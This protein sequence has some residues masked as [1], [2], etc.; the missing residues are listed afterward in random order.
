MAG[1]MV[2]GTSTTAVS[3]PPVKDQPENVDDTIVPGVKRDIESAGE[4]NSVEV[5]GAKRSKIEPNEEAAHQSKGL[6]SMLPPP[7][8]QEADAVVEQ[9]C[10]TKLT[11]G[12]KLEVLWEVGDDADEEAKP[13]AVFWPCHIDALVGAHAEL[14]PLWKLK[15]QQ[16]DVEGS[17][18]P[19]EERVV[20]FSAPHMLVDT[21]GENPDGEEESR[22]IM[23][24]RIEGTTPEL[25]ELL[26][27]GTTVWVR[28]AEAIPAALP[29]GDNA[30][31]AEVG[32]TGE[33]ATMHADGTYLVALDNGES[34]DRV[35]RQLLEVVDEEDGV[36]TQPHR[37][38]DASMIL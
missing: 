17:S 29:S 35:K 30:E 9:L 15:Y 3:H 5:E 36:R 21:G 7:P 13:T 26:P 22:L 4:T 2:E 19:A 6:E 10:G 37:R 38:V 23:Q 34:R 24:W 32:E 12:T 1:S 27:A 18:F 16:K 25:E 31:A 8:Q 28:A 20:A 33:I 11:L 14:G